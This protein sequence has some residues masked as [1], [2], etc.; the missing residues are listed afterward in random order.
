[1]LCLEI[2]KQPLYYATLSGTTELKDS[3]GQY[4]GE[5]ELTYSTPVYAKM[6]ISPARGGAQFGFFGINISYSKIMVTDDMDCPINEDTVLWIDANPTTDK[7]NY[8]VRRVAK[9]LNYISYAI[10]EVS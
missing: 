9:S 4:T 8:V 3:D 1:M 7:Y 2:N 6:N 10:E 5:Y